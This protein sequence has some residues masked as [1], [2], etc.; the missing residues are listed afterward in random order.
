[1]EFAG[2]PLSLQPC[3]PGTTSTTL[4]SCI[5]QADPTRVEARPSRTPQLPPPTPA[6]SGGGLV[7]TPPAGPGGAIVPTPTDNRTVNTSFNET[8]FGSYKISSIKCKALRDKIVQQTLG[9]LPRSKVNPSEPMCLAW[10]SKGQCNT[11][12]PCVADHV[13]YSATE[14][15]PMAAWC[16]IGY[17]PPA[18]AA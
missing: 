11:G 10:H 14:L 16:V 17:A 2:S 15:A 5:H 8:L 9:A 3:H 1:M 4:H 7:F 6:G 13:Q 12:C 18:P